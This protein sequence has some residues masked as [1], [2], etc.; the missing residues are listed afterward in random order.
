MSVLVTRHQARCAGFSGAWR[1]S[2][3][4]SCHRTLICR[5]SAFYAPIECNTDCLNDDPRFV[6]V[7]A[8][9]QATFRHQLVRSRFV[10]VPA[11]R[12][13]VITEQR[14]HCVDIGG[15]GVE[16]CAASSA[17]AR[18]SRCGLWYWRSCF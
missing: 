8:G 2:Q 18:W 11:T 14:S 15:C 4:F 10:P 6:Y 7:Y 16:R 17:E 12:N 3:V 1:C 13:A 5:M 9:A